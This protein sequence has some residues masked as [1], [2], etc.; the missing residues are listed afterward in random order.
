M[1]DVISVGNATQDIFIKKIAPEQSDAFETK[2]TESFKIGSKIEVDELKILPGG[3]GANTAVG[4]AKTG[5]STGIITQVGN[6]SLGKQIL[7]NL[8]RNGVS[9][10]NILKSNNYSSALSIILKSENGERTILVYRGASKKI[11]EEIIDLT[12][13]KTRWFYITS[14]GGDFGLIEKIL[15]LAKRNNA[16]VAFNPGNEELKNEIKIKRLIKQI[17]L[18]F[19]NKK[20]A[21]KLVNDRTNNLNIIIN[22]TRQF[23][24]NYIIITDG[25]NG[26]YALAKNN[27]FFAPA[28][29]TRPLD[30]TGAGDAFGSGFLSVIIKNNNDLKNALKFGTYNSS[31]VIQAWGAQTNLQTFFP[32]DFQINIKEEQYES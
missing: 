7:I 10:E 19:L 29:F 28:I 15:F 21:Q 18:L 5:L 9:T 1:Y 13:L 6:D 2:Q 32:N 11:N 17:N 25:E 26:A 4:I 3:G 16:F 14:V 20:E 24:K 23:L 30:S 27:Y 12:N 31:Q 8:H 22:K